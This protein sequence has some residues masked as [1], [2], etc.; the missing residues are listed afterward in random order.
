MDS[1]R[2]SQRYLQRRR[3]SLPA[4]LNSPDLKQNGEGKSSACSQKPVAEEE[5]VMQLSH[6][7]SEILKTYRRTGTVL[8]KQNR[9]WF[10]SSTGSPKEGSNS[11]R[12]STSYTRA[13][14]GSADMLTLT[15]KV[16]ALKDNPKLSIIRSDK[17]PANGKQTKELNNSGNN[18]L[19]VYNGE[20]RSRA[21]SWS[22][23]LSPR[24]SKAKPEGLPDGGSPSPDDS[25]S[26][27]ATPPPSYLLR[28]RRHSV[29]VVSGL[30][31]PR[32]ILKTPRSGRRPPTI[33]DSTFD[34]ASGMAGSKPGMYGNINFN[35]DVSDNIP[36]GSEAFRKALQCLAR[37]NQHKAADDYQEQERADS[38][39]EVV[40]SRIQESI[41]EIDQRHPSMTVEEEEDEDD[42]DDDDDSDDENA[43]ASSQKKHVHFCESEATYVP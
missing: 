11:P 25:D 22:P 8:A 13:R 43:T 33:W 4:V 3:Q 34:E 31:T 21:N 20:Y 15:A 35:G 18:H 16:K 6:N 27:C 9:P 5:T 19:Q 40:Y 24:R 12:P 41:P 1:P 10:I 29:G 32:S 7:I 17:A 14:R 2:P 36:D 38:D 26:P 37:H 30:S 42:D 39:N 23:V 28:G